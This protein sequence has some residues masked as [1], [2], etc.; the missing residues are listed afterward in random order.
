MLKYKYYKKIFYNLNAKVI[1][2]HRTIYKNYIN[3]QIDIL[4][5]YRNKE[6]SYILIAYFD[7]YPTIKLIR[8]AI[9]YEIEQTLFNFNKKQLLLEIY[10]NNKKNPSN[11]TS[12]CD[13]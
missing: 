13:D 6:F 8:N 9:V 4:M 7:S 1:S 5:L 12:Y 2:K 10:I 11:L 3:Y